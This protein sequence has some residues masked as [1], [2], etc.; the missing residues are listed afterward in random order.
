[1]RLAEKPALNPI[2]MAFAILKTLFRKADAR[3]IEAS[4]R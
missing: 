3:P 2:E 4:W 1:V